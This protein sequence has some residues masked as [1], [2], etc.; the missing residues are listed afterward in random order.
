LKHTLIISTEYFSGPL[1]QEKAISRLLDLVE[2]TAAHR[3]PGDKIT[4]QFSLDHWQ[5][6]SQGRVRPA[7]VLALHKHF[8]L[9]PLSQYGKPAVAPKNETF[10]DFKEAAASPNHRIAYGFSKNYGLP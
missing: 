5:D 6:L 8:T 2:T 3:T 7:N 4:D 9:T 1:A 10:A